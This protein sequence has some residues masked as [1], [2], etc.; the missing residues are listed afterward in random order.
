MF[1]LDFSDN[2]SASASSN[3]LIL[4]L[5]DD[6]EEVICVSPIKG[7]QSKINN[8]FFIQQNYRKFMVNIKERKSRGS[9]TKT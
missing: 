8:S 2:L 4:L 9:R 7:T 1:L 3:Q 5:V 6:E